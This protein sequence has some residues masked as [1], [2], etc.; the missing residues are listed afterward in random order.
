M[1]EVDPLTTEGDRPKGR[2][3]RPM[4]QVEAPAGQKQPPSGRPTEGSSI[5]LIDI[6]SHPSYL[7]VEPTDFVG[8]R[9][10][11]SS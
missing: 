11:I 10:R 5:F 2:I 4:G 7:S 1:G 6:L 3:D 9:L 8:E